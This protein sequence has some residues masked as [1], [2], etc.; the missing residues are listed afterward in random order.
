[1]SEYQYYE[2]QAID[3]PLDKAAQ[4]ALR[5]ISS[6]ALIT[7]VSFIT[8]YDYGELKG[9]PRTFMERWFDLHLYLA[10]WGT[11]RL[12]LR[13]PKRFLKQE[14]VDPFLRE[15]EL[16]DIRV[17]GEN[18]IVDLCRAEIEPYD[19]LDEGSGW[20][21]AIA[22]LRAE[23]LSGDFRLFYLVWLTAV[24]DDFLSDDD[25]EP[26]PG[27]GQLTA[28]LEA[29]AGFFDIDPDLVQAA[30]ESEVVDAPISRASLR[31]ELAAIPEDEKTELL[32]RLVEGG[33]N[34]VAAELKR[35]IR[36]KRPALSV[37][38]RTVG[39]LRER[40][41]EIAKARERAAAERQEAED[42]RK[43]EKAERAHRARLE[44]LR[45]RGADIWPEIES[46]IERRSA[47]GYNKAASL[48]SDLQALAVEEGS[49]AEFRRRLAAVRARHE[50]KGKFIERLEKLTVR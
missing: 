1:M 11:R 6:R 33:D 41:S 23:L 42:R 20:L 12:M 37:P 49:E 7:A 15:M 45:Q 13:L 21:A 40:A 10:D 36:D 44:E 16:V 25:L 50:K 47:A 3:R 27:I 38:C 46:E 48:L 30:T 9:D 32:V 22:P 28:A 35:R 29:F 31:K 4:E 24:Q 14:D 19:Y 18:V 2:F 5:S 34:H 39:A 43:A 17:C 8:S 26:M